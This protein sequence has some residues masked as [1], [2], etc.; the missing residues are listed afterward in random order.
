MNT[1]L[2][3]Y[4]A[5]PQTLRV[6]AKLNLRA[7][8]SS[9]AARVG[10][11]TPGLSLVADQL[12]D[13]EPYLG[14]S[15]WYRQAVTGH[16]FWA[17]GVMPLMGPRQAPPMTMVVHQRPDGSILPLSEGNIKK[18]FGDFSFVPAARIGAIRI[19]TP[20]WEAAH[21]ATLT[22]PALASVHPGGITLHQKAIP[23]FQA[24]FDAILAAGLAK[25]ILSFDGSFVAR[26]KGWNPNRGLSSHSWGIAIDLNTAWNG[27]G[28]APAPLGSLG[29]VQELLPHFAAQGIAWGGD[30]SKPDTDG[31]HFELARLDV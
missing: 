6:S 2:A 11:V 4:T 8:P 1:L 14:N 28:K 20:G 15:H 12:L 18:I 26:H 31:M 21:L 10:R 13:A 23:S 22:H 17:G 27:Y 3:D 24:A 5:A 29:S 9:S 19:S 7:A 30:F 16:F 25:L